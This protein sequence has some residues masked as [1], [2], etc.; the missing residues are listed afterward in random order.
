MGKF[1]PGKQ[2]DD[3]GNVCVCAMAYHSRV[4]GFEI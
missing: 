4:F 2:A 1:E 3:R